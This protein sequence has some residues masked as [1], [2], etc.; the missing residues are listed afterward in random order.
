VGGLPSCTVVRRGSHAPARAGLCAPSL[1]IFS[2]KSWNLLPPTSVGGALSDRPSR[3]CLVCSPSRRRKHLSNVTSARGGRSL[4]T[5]GRLSRVIF[6]SAAEFAPSASVLTPAEFSMTVSHAFSRY[7][8]VSALALLVACTDAPE[9]ARGVTHGAMPRS[10]PGGARATLEAGHDTAE[11]G[12]HPSLSSE[13][14]TSMPALV[15]GPCADC[16]TNLSNYHPVGAAVSCVNCHGGDASTGPFVPI[17]SS[18]PTAPPAPT[19]PPV[20]TAP[21]A[22]TAPPTPTTPPPSTAPPPPTA[23]PAAPSPGT[24]STL[25]PG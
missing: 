22:P 24:A 23:A 10:T 17:P 4:A 19:A 15:L 18:P 21:P 3:H 5:K 7:T 1:A 13:P 9:P 2:R 12:L 20:P 16:H 25:V 6:R 14:P 11:F 8:L